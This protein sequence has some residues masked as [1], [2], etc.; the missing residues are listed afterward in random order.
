MLDDSTVDPDL[1][2]ESAPWVR[3]LARSLVRDA[4]LAED[5]AQEVM[6]AALVQP[7][8]PS[9]PERLRGWLAGITRHLAWRA[10]SRELERPTRELRAARPEVD[11]GESL[12]RL[13]VHH[14]LVEAVMSLNEP[15]RTAITLRYF[16][17]LPPREI[18][19]RTGASPAT[20]RQHVS[21]GLAQLRERLDDD[22]GS[23]PT[24]VGALGGVLGAGPLAWYPIAKGALMGS[25]KIAVAS[26]LA[27]AAAGVAGWFATRTSEIEFAPDVNHELARLDSL[28]ALEA[29]HDAALH[30]SKSER[31]AIESSVAIPMLSVRVLAPDGQPVD[32]DVLLTVAGELA[33]RGLATA[34]SGVQFEVRDEPGILLAYRQAFPVARL[35]LSELTGTHDILL[36]PGAI[37]AGVLVEDGHV[38]RWPI[39]L[40]LITS[41][42]HLAGLGDSAV[43]ALEQLG[44]PGAE[45]RVVTGGA[46]DFQYAGLT[47]DCKPRIQLPYTH[48]FSA[49]PDGGPILSV[50]E[51][52]ASLAA[53]AEGLRV[54]VT[55]LP[56]IRGRIVWKDTHE[57]V[58]GV[59]LMAWAEFVDDATSSSYGF[60]GQA[61]GTFAIGLW[62]SSLSDRA[63]WQTAELR[64]AIRVL[65]LRIESGGALLAREIRFSYE[66]LADDCFV[67]DVE[68]ERGRAAYFLVR[69]P[70]GEPVAGALVRADG[71]TVQTDVDGRVVLGGLQEAPDFAVVGARGYGI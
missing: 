25:K 26:G 68:V 20:A 35:E 32:A 10:R 7:G 27:V 50:S 30:V 53:P 52:R 34:R 17:D 43:R 40:T 5:V 37:L 60:T 6:T 51:H 22:F 57:P 23:R 15:Y 55:R 12:E 69:G 33:D 63:R 54:R 11:T 14:K 13:R 71:S 3:R 21:R 65:R 67:G 41:A 61:D 56:G 58:P 44:A 62:S 9:S 2:L 24:W 42:P 66:E 8:A 45:Q 70:S 39:E 4:H 28:D 64:P 46:G 1:L 49:P 16:D 47:A 38:P 59:S 31:A 19:R 36:E 18:A 48:G 29:E